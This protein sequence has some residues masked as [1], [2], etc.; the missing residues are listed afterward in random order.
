MNKKV[1]LSV[2]VIVL[3]IAAVGGATMAWFTDAEELTNTFT[4]GTLIIDADDE[5]RELIGEDWTNAN[6]GDCKEKDFTVKNDGTK[7]MFVRFSFDGAWVT[8]LPNAPVGFVPDNDLVT[9]KPAVGDLDNWTFVDGYWYYNGLLESGDE[10]TFTFLVCLDGPGADNDYQGAKFAIT[11]NFEAIQVTNEAVNDVW[12]VYWDEGT[13]AWVVV[14][15][16]VTP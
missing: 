7:R 1:V 11:F 15:P 9:I 4:A 3:A 16:V 6:P 10:I 2:L 12:G 14:P 5:W 8:P 13:S